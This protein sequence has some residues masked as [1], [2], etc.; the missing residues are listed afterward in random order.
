MCLLN[1]AACKGN[2]Q[3]QRIEE[4]NRW[5]VAIETGDPHLIHTDLRLVIMR[6]PTGTI[7]RAEANRRVG[8]RK[9]IATAIITRVI[10]ALEKAVEI[11]RKK[12]EIAHAM[13]MTLVIR[14]TDIQE[15]K[16]HKPKE[17]AVAAA[18]ATKM[19]AEVKDINHRREG[20]TGIAPPM[21]KVTT[22]RPLPLTATTA[23][24]ISSSRVVMAG[25]VRR[26]PIATTTTGTHRRTAS[27]HTTEE[28]VTARAKMAEAG[29]E[30]VVAVV[31]T[32]GIVMTAIARAVT[33]RTT[34]AIG[35]TAVEAVAVSA[36]TSERL[37]AFC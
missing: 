22:I 29:T 14:K 7:I 8:G 28:A 21:A 3:G 11:M 12:T 31:I 1:L 18:V 19:K 16:I 23:T 36:G 13:E 4:A 25:A 2:D 30:V 35:K 10:T 20:T 34:I 6:L 27:R 33:A 32:T 24:K 37:C 5:N 15:R 9:T 17:V 26:T